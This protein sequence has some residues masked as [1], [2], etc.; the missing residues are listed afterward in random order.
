MSR[1]N[2][3]VLC[4]G[5]PASTFAWLHEL[6]SRNFVYGVTVACEGE[7]DVQERMRAIR[8]RLAEIH[9]RYR[10]LNKPNLHEFVVTGAPSWYRRLMMGFH[11]ANVT[12]YRHVYQ[13]PKRIVLGTRPRD[14]ELCTLCDAFARRGYMV[15]APWERANHEDLLDT[16]GLWELVK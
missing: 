12:T 9:S 3:I 5:G 14:E 2:V 6:L 7:E 16:Y 13:A 1:E 10:G 4:S 11:V 8:D 15:C